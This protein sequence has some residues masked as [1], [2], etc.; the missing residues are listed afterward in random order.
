MLSIDKMR[1]CTGCEKKGNKRNDGFM[2]DKDGEW[3]CEDPCYTSLKDKYKCAPQPSKDDETDD[4]K[5]EEHYE[6]VFDEEKCELFPIPLRDGMRAKD[7]DGA[8]WIA[9]D[10]AWWPMNA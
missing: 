8:W 5:E 1:V 4:E 2:V 6:P 3:Y 10:D 9:R 7:V